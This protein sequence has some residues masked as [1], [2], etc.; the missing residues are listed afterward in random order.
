MYAFAADTGKLRWRYRTG[1]RV[2][3]GLAYSA[4]KVFVGSYDHHVYALNAGTGRLIWRA[5]A[6]LRLGSQ[7]TFYE[8]AMTAAGT[9]PKI[10]LSRLRIPMNVP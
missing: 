2:K 6:Q 4:G 3:G 5:A 10:S 1:G 7:G 9:F 8:G